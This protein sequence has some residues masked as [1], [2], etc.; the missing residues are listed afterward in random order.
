VKELFFV[1][2]LDTF[3]YFASWWSEV[4]CFVQFVVLQINYEVIKLQEY[5]L[6]RH[7]GD[8][9][10]LRHLNYVIKM[11]SQK[12]SIFKP[13][14]PISKVLVRSLAVTVNNTLFLVVLNVVFRWNYVI[15]FWT[16]VIRSNAKATSLC[17]TFKAYHWVTDWPW[18]RGIGREN[19]NGHTN[20]L[21]SSVI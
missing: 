10:Q 9:I 18:A 12:F 20:T 11:A 16:D 21:Y 1:K 3:E 15:A 8:V 6:W 14:P 4:T 2:I 7:F 13:L 5:Q 19:N 17:F